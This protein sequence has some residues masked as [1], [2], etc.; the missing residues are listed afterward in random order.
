[1]GMLRWPPPREALRRRKE[2]PHHE[3]V[4]PLTLDLTFRK[5]DFQGAWLPRVQ[6]V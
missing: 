3:A 6:P 1:M 4:A 2:P 5:E